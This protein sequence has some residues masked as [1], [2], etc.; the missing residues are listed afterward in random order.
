MQLAP[1]GKIYMSSTS[2]I[3]SLHVIH[4]PDEPGSACQFQA[5]GLPLPARNSFSV[6]YSPNYRL[7]P[8]DGS[9][10]DTLGLDNRPIA[11]F[12]Y[13]RDTMDSLSVYFHDLSYY[14]PTS[15]SWDFG[16]G[17][18]ST[19][20][21]P[22]HTYASAGKYEVCLTVSNAHATNTFCRTL[23]L[24]VSASDDP[25][26]QERISVFPNPFHMQLVVAAGSNLRNGMFYL[27]DLSGRLV[28]Q[29]TT[30]IGVREMETGDL[31]RGIYFWEVR[32]A[33]E[34]VCGGKVV[35]M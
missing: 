29:V 35:K 34:R 8:L 2:T 25:E 12:R 21:H 33:G 16:D 32:E 31:A 15:W 4:Q 5:Y 18:I 28:R 13:Q 22:V 26:I 14:E 19:A 11:W 27:Y 6:T 7:G 17:T 3:R 10:C 24:G 23:F 1:D 20:R 30:L 9:S